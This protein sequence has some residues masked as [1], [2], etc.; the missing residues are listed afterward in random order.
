MSELT[1]RPRQIAKTFI[2]N[3]LL[4]TAGLFVIWLFA[5]V[6][7]FFYRP[8]D[9]RLHLGCGSVRKEGFINIDHRLS[10]TVD[11]VLDIRRLPFP[12]GSVSRIE[13]YHVIEH[14]PQRRIPA[15]IDNWCNVLMEDGELVIECPDVD[16]T[17]TEYL[18]GNRDRIY[19]IYG[20][21][22]F[23][24]D[25]HYFGY[26]PEQLTELL[27]AHGF[28]DCRHEEPTDYHK[29]TEPCMRIVCKKGKGNN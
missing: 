11:I 26:N 2:N 22:R 13:C 17:M 5:K 29:E 9:L 18:A 7:F 21:D 6:L 28:G 14:I 1:G 3:V 25:I 24:G 19:N 16:R 20:M 10:R 15:T 27:K 4:G 12:A 23:K 8:K